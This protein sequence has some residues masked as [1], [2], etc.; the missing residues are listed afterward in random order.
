MQLSTLVQ[1]TFGYIDPEYMQTRQL[2][3][4]SDVYSFGAVLVELLTGKKI[5]SD[6]RP[7]E[8][9]NMAKYFVLSMK[10]NRLFDVLED[11]VMHGGNHTQLQ[12]VANLAEQCLRLNGEERPTMREVAV[13]LDYL[14]G[15]GV[16]KHSWVKEN[17]DEESVHLLVES[18]LDSQIESS[19]RGIDSL[20]NQVILSLDGAR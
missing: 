2:F 3:D 18:S 16:G 9:K 20:K 5:Y 11:E 13:E 19:T 10:Q 17:Y 7:E 8:R 15:R 14:R 1:G 6:D 4:K 12:G